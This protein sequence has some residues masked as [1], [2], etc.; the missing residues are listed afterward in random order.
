[1]DGRGPRASQDG[2]GRH[3]TTQDSRQALLGL[4]HSVGVLH[5]VRDVAACT[6]AGLWV[7]H[8]K[9]DVQQGQ[10]GQPV[11][12]MGDWVIQTQHYVLFSQMPRE[13]NDVAEG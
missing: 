3:W 7:L 11:R 6:L 13:P 2:T 1:M 8:E 4:E 5:L 9:V 12:S 10:W